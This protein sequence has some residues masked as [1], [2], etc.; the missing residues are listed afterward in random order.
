MDVSIDFIEGLPKLE[1]K[2]VIMVVVVVDR[3]SKYAHFVTLAHL[4]T[5]LEVAK[6]YLDNVYKLH[7]TPTSIISNRDKV[8][9]S[10][11]WSELFKLLGTK[12]IAYYP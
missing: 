6:A 11:F 10:R 5:A 9:L 1:R 3:L 4:F 12:L 8:F 2:K 7:G